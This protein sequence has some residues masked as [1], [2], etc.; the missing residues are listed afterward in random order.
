MTQDHLCHFSR[1][2]E[3]FPSSVEARLL[4]SHIFSNELFVT[5]NEDWVCFE[6]NPIIELVGSFTQE[7]HVCV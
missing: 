4:L 1:V 6:V 2:Q 5:R 3:G 7:H